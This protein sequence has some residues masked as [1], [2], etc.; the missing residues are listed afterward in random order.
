M[1]I[2]GQLQ[3]QVFRTASALSWLFVFG[4]AVKV[5]TT[6]AGLLNR[7]SPFLS[8]RLKRWNWWGSKLS[9]LLVCASALLL[10]WR[11]GDVAGT[12]VFGVLLLLALQTVVV[13]A[14]RRARTLPS[15]AG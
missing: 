7:S 8:T 10:C 1:D 5:A 3:F 12:A 14:A 4:I 15:R 2:A 9:A 11:A 6:V 13:L